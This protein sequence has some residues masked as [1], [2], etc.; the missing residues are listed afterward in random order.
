[1]CAWT[2]FDICVRKKS[3]SCEATSNRLKGCDRKPRTP[4]THILAQTRGALRTRQIK[5]DAEPA[6]RRHAIAKL[7]LDWE[8]LK[9]ALGRKAYN[10]NQ[11]RVPAGGREGGQWTSEGTLGTPTRLAAK[12]PGIGHNKPPVPG[13]SPVPKIPQQQPPTSAE[14]TAVYKQ[15]ATWLLEKGKMAADVIAKTSWLYPAIPLINSYMDP[16]K[17]EEELR[18]AALKPSQAGYQDH[19]V[20]GRAA[21]KDGILSNQIYTPEMLSAFQQ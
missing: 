5:F 9:F 7:R 16:P 12:L 15:L 21:E 2:L 4:S 11:P 18:Q 13:K 8:L 6:W 3:S 10:P 17:T 19:H 1:M 14:R 20:V